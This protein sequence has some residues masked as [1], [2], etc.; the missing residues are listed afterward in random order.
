MLKKW[1]KKLHHLVL[2][3]LGIVSNNIY[4]VR[5]WNAVL[6]LDIF[7]CMSVS[8]CLYQEIV[9]KKIDECTK[10]EIIRAKHIL[11]GTIAQLT[12]R[13]SV[14]IYNT[15][16][17]YKTKVYLLYY[18]KGLKFSL[19]SNRRIRYPIW[20]LYKRWYSKCCPFSR[21]LIA[22]NVVRNGDCH[23]NVETFFCY[24][25]WFWWFII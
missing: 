6:L 9:Q 22:E 25:G 5:D 21:L 10:I 19:Y 12:K 23:K 18:L 1:A 8:V 16:L 14:L 7:V 2:K 17:I 15:A 13:Y 20:H 24:L 4:F 11:F 3:S